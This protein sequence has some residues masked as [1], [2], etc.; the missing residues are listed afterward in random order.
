MSLQSLEMEGDGIVCARGGRG[1]IGE[2]GRVQV[3]SAGRDTRRRALS[4]EGGRSGT[5]ASPGQ[6][7]P[8]AGPAAPRPV[9]AFHTA[10]QETDGGGGCLAPHIAR[11]HE[12]SRQQRMFGTEIF[13][14]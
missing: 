11:I 5:A 14:T 10:P 4:G 13:D 6:F 1:D 8:P 7:L 3:D 2:A 12:L 9:A